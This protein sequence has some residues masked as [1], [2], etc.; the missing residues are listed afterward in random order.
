VDDPYG[1]VRGIMEAVCPG[2]YLVVSHGAADIDAENM[3]LP[4]K[5]LSEGSLGDVRVAFPSDVAQFFEWTGSSR[6]TAGSDASSDTRA[7]GSTAFAGSWSRSGSS[8]MD[9]GAGE[10]SVS[11]EALS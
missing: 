6:S 10:E 5:R 11:R 1:I 3:A 2:S 9:V 4:T 7:V 8:G